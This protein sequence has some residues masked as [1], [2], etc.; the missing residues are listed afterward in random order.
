MYRITKAWI[1]L[2][3]GDQIKIEKIDQFFMYILKRLKEEEDKFKRRETNMGKI[4][5]KMKNVPILSEVFAST[6][7]RETAFALQKFFADS[8]AVAIVLK[9]NDTTST[10]VDWF[11]NDW[12]ISMIKLWHK[13][14]GKTVLQN[15][16]NTS[17]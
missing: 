4:I 3:K 7:N 9:R 13:H 1:D 2:N 8:F 12:T 6:R 17:K 15:N 14:N 16:K 10:Y 5:K 11:L